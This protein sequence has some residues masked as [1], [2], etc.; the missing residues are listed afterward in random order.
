[1]EDLERCL[2]GIGCV[3]ENVFYSKIAPVAG[4]AKNIR[5]M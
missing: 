3:G 4:Q 1:M 5:R 2:Y